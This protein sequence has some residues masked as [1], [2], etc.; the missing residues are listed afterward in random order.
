MS[1]YAVTL[2]GGSG[3]RLW[4]L[5]RESCPKQ[6]LDLLG[7]GQTM[8][9]A[10]VRRVRPLTEKVIVVTNQKQAEIVRRQL[11]GAKIVIEPQ[12]RNTAP[13][14]GLAAIHILKEDPEAVMV[15]LPCD[16]FFQDSLALV[17]VLGAAVDCAVKTNLLVTIGLEPTFAHPKLGYIVP[18]S[19]LGVGEEEG[20]KVQRFVEKPGTDKAALLI[21][22]EN[23][24]WNSG[25]FVWKVSTFLDI[26]SKTAP[27]IHAGLMEIAASIGTDQEAA[28][29][30]RVFPT[31]ESISV[32]FAVMERA[33]E[34][35]AVIPGRG[36]GWCD[37]GS[38]DILAQFGV[39]D[40]QQ[41]S[42]FTQGGAKVLTPDVGSAVTRDCI[43]HSDHGVLVVAGCEGLVVVRRGDAV[44]VI[45]KKLL[46]ALGDIVKTFPPEVK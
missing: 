38:W 9:Q 37:I 28:V 8:I 17:T 27:A 23:A 42:A 4:P 36:L 2:S 20:L 10:T 29:T 31:L 16:H 11:S 13:A 6:F 3:T 45:P 33:P 30:A 22:Q 1:I 44:L 19:H 39:Q 5:S 41:N 46:S 25:M 24:L 7:E 34:S 12:A 43:I 15:A 40:E 35:I 32:D 14:I 26:L 18:G 21:E